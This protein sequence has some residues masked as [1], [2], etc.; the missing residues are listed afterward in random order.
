KMTLAHIPDV[1][2]IERHSFTAPS[3]KESFLYHILHNHYTHYFLIQQHQHPLAYSR[4]SILMDH[5]QITN[6]AILPQHRANRYGE[7][8]LRYVIQF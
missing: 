6:I 4:V 5:A 8:F 2:T 1:Y 3:K 7:P